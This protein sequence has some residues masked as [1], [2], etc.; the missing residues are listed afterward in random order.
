MI[1]T[2][3]CFG[4]AKADQAWISNALLLRTD[5]SKETGRNDPA[6]CHKKR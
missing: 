4:K 2:N 1:A 5:Y 3:A 6:D